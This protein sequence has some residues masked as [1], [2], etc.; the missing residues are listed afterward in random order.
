MQ[1]IENVVCIINCVEEMTLKE[2]KNA[3]MWIEWAVRHTKP[4][5]A[6][7]EKEEKGK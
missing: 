6:E 4:K 2:R 3:H 1:R 7:D 5:L